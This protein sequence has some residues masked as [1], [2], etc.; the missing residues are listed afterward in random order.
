M[1][2]NFTIGA[3]EYE[4]P[5]VITVDRFEK[6]M[7]WDLQDLKNIKQKNESG[8]FEFSPRC[9]ATLVTQLLD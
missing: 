3:K 7:A 4:V 6:A 2:V 5:E 9:R 8:H 1:E